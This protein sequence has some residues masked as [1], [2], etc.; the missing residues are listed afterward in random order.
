[1]ISGRAGRCGPILS[2]GTGRVRRE[3][4]DYGRSAKKNH[5]QRDQQPGP[6]KH[7]GRHQLLGGGGFGRHQASRVRRARVEEE[8]EDPDVGGKV[9]ERISDPPTG[10]NPEHHEEGKDPERVLRRVNLVPSQERG[11]Q[12]GGGCDEREEAF[13]SVT[14]PSDHH[15]DESE[16]GDQQPGDEIERCRLHERNRYRAKVSYRPNRIEVRPSGAVKPIGRPPPVEVGEDERKV[17]DRKHPTS[18]TGG[19]SSPLQPPPR[20]LIE[21]ERSNKQKRVKLERPA[22]SEADR[23]LSRQAS[24][25]KPETGDGGRD[26]E[27]IPVVKRV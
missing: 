6:G 3:S 4:L 20:K 7:S 18:D 22:K 9:G 24:P 21:S 25:P 26:C 14:P 5:E 27:Q 1:M 19:G 2:D 23:G 11:E 15:C 17:D 13:V 16:Q 8:P 10:V 12:G